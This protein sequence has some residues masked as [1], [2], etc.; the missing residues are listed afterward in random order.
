MAMC[1]DDCE[2]NAMQ[3]MSKLSVESELATC[4]S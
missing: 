3:L 4:S 2:R 1:I